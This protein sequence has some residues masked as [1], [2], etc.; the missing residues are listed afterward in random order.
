MKFDVTVATQGPLFTGM[1]ATTMQKAV[2]SGIREIVQK[3]EQRLA[4]QLRPRP[5]GVFLST[6]QAGPRTG[7]YRRSISTEFKNM[8]AMIHDNNVEYGPWLEGVGSRNET[9]RFKGYHQ[10]KATGTY[11]QKI[12]KKIMDAHARHWAKRMNA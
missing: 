12:S 6:E 7:H 8:S 11:L 4:E 2:N 3:G 10:Y 9:S 5:A 1:A